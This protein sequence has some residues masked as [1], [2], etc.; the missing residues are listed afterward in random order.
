MWEGNEANKRKRKCKKRK[1]G[2]NR[3]I[4]KERNR[5]NA[6]RGE[7][8][9]DKTR[10]EGGTHL[11]FKKLFSSAYKVAINT[12]IMLHNWLPKIK[13]GNYYILYTL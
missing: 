8:R 12:E 13:K 2:G 4:R 9:G 11:S 1:E 5:K 3:G 7:E 10:N 6:E